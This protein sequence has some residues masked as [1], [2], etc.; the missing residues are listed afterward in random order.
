MPGPGPPQHPRGTG[1]SLPYWKP[2]GFETW[3]GARGTQSSDAAPRS[4]HDCTRQAALPSQVPDKPHEPLR[5]LTWMDAQT[6]RLGAAR[7][8]IPLLDRRTRAPTVPLLDRTL[9]CSTRG[10]GE[11]PAP[12]GPVGRAR[13]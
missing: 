11:R 7:L 4:P 13:R 8:T 6:T 10:P 2:E 12:G 3:A 5:T 1:S 9:S